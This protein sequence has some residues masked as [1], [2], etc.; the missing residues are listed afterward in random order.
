MRFAPVAQLEEQIR[1]KDKVVGST[2]IRG[3]FTS[4]FGLFLIFLRLRISPSLPL[5]VLPDI[6]CLKKIKNK[7]KILVKPLGY[8]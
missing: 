7:R 8:V 4:A 5:G 2:P 3:V 1:P 6:P